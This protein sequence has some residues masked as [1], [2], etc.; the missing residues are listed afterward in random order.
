LVNTL[1]KRL[2]KPFSG[3]SSVARKVMQT[4]SFPCPA[5]APSLS[6]STAHSCSLPHVLQTFILQR[7]MTSQENQPHM[8]PLCV[9]DTFSCCVI[10]IHDIL[11]FF[12]LCA[13]TSQDDRPHLLP[14]CVLD[15]LILSFDLYPQHLYLFLVACKGLAARFRSFSR[16]LR[17]L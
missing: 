13:R 16:L 6:S 7:A 2:L 4:I 12:L 11:T 3:L 1:K 17:I 9:L 10:C 15:T 14:L 5:P 8:P